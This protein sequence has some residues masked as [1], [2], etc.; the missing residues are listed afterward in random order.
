MAKSELDLYCFSIIVAVTFILSS[1]NLFAQVQFQSHTIAGGE[2][3]VLSASH[4]KAGDLDLDG[5]TDIIVVSNRRDK[6]DWLENDG[7]QNFTQHTIIDYAIGINYVETI[8]LDGDGDIDLVSSSFDENRVRWYENYGNKVFGVRTIDLQA[9]GAKWV[10]AGDFDGD[11]DIDVLGGG[12]PWEQPAF[13]KLYQN[14]GVQNFTAQGIGSISDFGK[15][16]SISDI[17]NDGDLDFLTF[18][19]SKVIW[20]E[21]DSFGNFSLNIISQAIQGSGTVTAVDINNDGFIDIVVQSESSFRRLMNDGMM[22]FTEFFISNTTGNLVQTFAAD[23]EGDGDIDFVSAHENRQIYFF[24]NIDNIS[25]DR[26]ILNSGQKVRSTFPVDLDSDGFMDILFG[27]NV[28]SAGFEVPVLSWHKSDTLGQF[29]ED[30]LLSDFIA[31]Y[32]TITLNDFNSDGILDIVATIEHRERIIWFKNDANNNFQESLLSEDNLGLRRIAIRDIDKDSFKDFA[33]VT[34]YHDEVAWLKN[35]GDTT[36]SRIEI[37]E[38]YTSWPRGVAVVDL[39]TDGDEDVIVAS[40]DH[41][42]W[43]E[44]DGNQSF[45]LSVMSEVPNAGRQV[46]PVD[47]DF[48]GDLDLYARSFYGVYYLEN[49]GGQMFTLNNLYVGQNTLHTPVKSADFGAD[50][51]SDAVFVNNNGELVLAEY[52]NG[53]HFNINILANNYSGPFEV[54]DM[55]S[56]MHPDIVILNNYSPNNKLFLLQNDGNGQFS[57]FQ[58]ADNFRRGLDLKLGDLD[59]DGDIDIALASILDQKLSWYENLTPVGIEDETSMAFKT[60]DLKQNYPNPFNPTTTIRYSLPNTQR[61]TLA[62][63]N[64]QGQKVRTLINFTQQTNE[65]QAVWD[66]RND[67]G[68]AVSSG[69][70]VYRLTA[71]EFSES[72]KMVLLR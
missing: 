25:Y 12:K 42:V 37:N 16:I 21:N 9:F 54:V 17:D 4:L 27:G 56:D 45:N 35:S 19:N 11:G 53:G 43:Y 46:L 72:R 47:V 14:D 40:I 13:I 63:Y 34:E 31:D 68:E 23:F 22:N 36:F 59:A 49:D 52:V 24:R 57:S 71:G 30:T 66:G 28:G 51:D 69:V 20:M 48:D 61:V 41:F 32:E 6:L 5:D 50:G 8:D 7:H 29:V 15:N 26:V 60:F 62:I 3:G 38:I 33:I 10:G 39:D 2:L 18:F 1:Q 70:Y 64:L 58:I 44:N 55:N 65:H 67:S